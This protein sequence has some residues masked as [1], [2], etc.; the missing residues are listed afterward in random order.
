MNVPCLSIPS[1]GHSSTGQLLQ[2]GLPCLSFG[3][4]YYRSNNLVA[5]RL[6]IK[7]VASEGPG[8]RSTKAM[9]ILWVRMQV[10]DSVLSLASPTAPSHFT[11][12]A[13]PSSDPCPSPSGPVRVPSRTSASTRYTTSRTTT[14][15]APPNQRTTRVVKRLW[16]GVN[17]WNQQPKWSRVRLPTS[18]VKSF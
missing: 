9:D 10:F 12:C 6:H 2:V 13:G 16:E 11:G 1:S 3:T 15:T 5:F 14:I 18:E 4:S 8:S 17:G 7:T